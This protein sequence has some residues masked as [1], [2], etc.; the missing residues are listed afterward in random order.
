LKVVS[1]LNTLGEFSPSP[2]TREEYAVCS[3]YI[4]L[5]V[6]NNTVNG[7]RNIILEF[8]KKFVMRREFIRK[9]ILNFIG[10]PE[11]NR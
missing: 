1:K 10:Q 9:C 3:V 2:W 11:R 8:K 5:D 7:I 4:F 6:I